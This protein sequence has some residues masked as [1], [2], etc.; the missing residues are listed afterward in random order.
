MY[1]KTK[2]T[3][4]SP[5]DFGAANSLVAEVWP[6]REAAKAE[7]ADPYLTALSAMFM[8]IDQADECGQLIARRVKLNKACSEFLERQKLS[9][10]E[11]LLAQYEELKQAGRKQQAKI[12]AF[13][14]DLAQWERNLFDRKDAVARAVANLRA[15]DQARNNL[16]RFASAAEI[17]A[18]DVKLEKA[19]QKLDA[20]NAAEGEVQQHLNS[21]KL[22][23]FPPLVEEL[24]RIAG[25]E[26]KLAAQLSGESYFEN[27]V[28]IQAAV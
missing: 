5:A 28:E 27:G 16:G 14:Q 7:L 19:V 18:A 24:K 4:V 6:P 11:T 2:E 12:D 26:E 8:D 17:T 22:T 23:V 1:R 20:A 15:V 10:R 3:Q 13:S 9:K 25:E 21:L